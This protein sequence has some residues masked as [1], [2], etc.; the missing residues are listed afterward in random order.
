VPLLPIHG[1]TALR[2]RFDD[3]IK[4]NVLPGSLLLHGPLGVGKQRLALWLGQRLLCTGPEPRPCGTCQHCRYAVAGTHP[5]IHW[6]FPRPSLKSGDATP[7]KVN[8]DLREAIGE[9]LKT[10]AYAPAPPGE[11]IYVA[12]IQAMVQSAAMAPALGARKVYIVGE[13][14][15]MVL[16]EGA[17]D[18]AGAFLK[19]LEEPPARATIVL[20]SAEPGALIPTIRSR[21]VA[22]R[23]A[24]LGTADVD[25]VLAEPAMQAAIKEAGGPK[26]TVEQRRVANGAPGVLL[27]EAEWAEAVARARRML[28]A[29]SS[30][31][32]REQIK[33][34]MIQGASRARGAFTTS[35]DALTTL[36]HERV[37]ESAAKGNSRDA[38]S[39]ARALDRVE[40]AK[41]RATGNV[42]PQLITSELLRE[43]EELLA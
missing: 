30:G 32:R 13:A 12:T 31:N 34:A 38:V 24:P 26:S 36:L 25:A 1:H 6:Y 42:N 21:L 28:D 2:S 7:A 35:L 41:E 14:E 9:R 19:L 8:D 22:V 39:T 11:G 40:I 20:T 27:A 37:R 29:A 33:T 4:R 3:A 16:R 10:G 18:S 5:D 15:R 23:V 43:L 17:E